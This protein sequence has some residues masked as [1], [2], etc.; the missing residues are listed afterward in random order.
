MRNKITSAIFTFLLCIPFWGHAQTIEVK[1]TITL[2]HYNLLMYG[3]N[4]SACSSGFDLDVNAKDAEFKKIIDHVQPDVLTVNEMGCNSVYITRILQ[5]V[6]NTNGQKYSSHLLQKEGTQ[7]MCNALFYKHDKLGLS[8]TTKI[9]KGIT[10]STFVRA[11]DLHSLYVK[12]KY[13][14]EGRDTVKYDHL[15]AHLK[16]SSGSANVAERAYAAEGIMDYLIS[17]KNVGNFILSGDFNM[18]TNTEDGYQ[19]LTKLTN[20]SYK[21]NDPISQEGKWNNNSNY[22]PYHTQ[23][24][25]SSGSC[26]GMDDRFDMILASNDII[27]N[28]KKIRYIPGSYKALG[29]DGKRFNGSIISP[30][31]TAVPN[32]IANAL[33]NMSDHL[34][35]VMQ[36]EASY[37]V[38][39]ITDGYNEIRNNT[40]ITIVSPS[41]GGAK[42]YSQSSIFEKLNYSIYS[43]SGKL[44]KEG[45]IE[46]NEGFHSH[47]ISFDENGIFAFR[48]EEPNGQIRTYKIVKW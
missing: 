23:N 43:I 12:G 8:N 9:T 38:N 30:T 16:A 48:L 5:Y 15:I 21:F 42:F 14:E 13:L 11:I 1:D 20:L 35:V 2:M 34:P 31:N 45:F 7:N 18:Y 17:N 19:K 3:I 26:G 32:N 37:E 44:I 46:I 28:G 41:N 33:Y 40:E 25:R 29:Q 6:L 4:G 24:T 10:G 36:M 27:S 22:A 39:D 47:E